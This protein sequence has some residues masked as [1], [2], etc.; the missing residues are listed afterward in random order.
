MGCR[1]KRKRWEFEDELSEVEKGGGE[2]D[3]RERKEISVKM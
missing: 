2:T 3:P 1:G